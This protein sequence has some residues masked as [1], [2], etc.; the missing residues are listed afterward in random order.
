MSRGFNNAKDD[1]SEHILHSVFFS[2]EDETEASQKFEFRVEYVRKEKIII[3][4]F[5]LT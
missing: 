5:L 1:L 2:L 3:K 4:T